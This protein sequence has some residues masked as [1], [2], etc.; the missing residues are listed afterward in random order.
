MRDTQAMPVSGVFDVG[1]A[2][3]SIVE[4]V[5]GLDIAE[6]QRLTGLTFVAAPLAA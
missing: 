4:T 2:G 1:P 5:E 3:A 6:L